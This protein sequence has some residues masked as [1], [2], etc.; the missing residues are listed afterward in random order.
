[1]TLASKELG[2]IAGMERQYILLNAMP[3]VAR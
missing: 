1:V 3:L 2:S